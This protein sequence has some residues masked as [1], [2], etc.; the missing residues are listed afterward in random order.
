MGLKCEIKE[1]I[2][3]ADAWKVYFCCHRDEYKEYKDKMKDIVLDISGVECA[4]YYDE[5]P[6]GKKDEDW[7]E[8]LLNMNLFVVIITRKFLSG[9]NQAK[10]EFF[11]A[12]Q[13]G[14]PV[15]PIV[16]DARLM[17]AFNQISNGVHALLADE[18]INKSK[19]QLKQNLTAY[20]NAVLIN[21]ELLRRIHEVSDGHLFMSYRKKD[22]KHLMELINEIHEDDRCIDIPI[23][24]DDF[25]VPGERFDDLIEEKLLDGSIF[26]LTVTP[27]LIK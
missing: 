11:Y 8:L 23:W 6:K 22:R 9:E 3:R 5:K 19:R 18:T 2:K 16:T 25:L 12:R 10:K 7:N 17:N 13:Q 1:N 26:V 4:F 21:N 15:I 27:N 24:Y 14:I 20:M